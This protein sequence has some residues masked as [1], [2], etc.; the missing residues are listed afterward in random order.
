MAR[1][2]VTPQTVTSS[3]LVPA[4]EPANVDG[5]SFTPKPGRALRVTNGSAASVNVTVVTPGV[6]DGDLP[7]PDRVVAVAAGTTRYFAGLGP[8]FRQADGTVHINY[9]AVAS[10]TVALLDA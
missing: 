4:T 2:A 9:S 10:V 1:S 5:H 3:G 6:A 7:I 8:V